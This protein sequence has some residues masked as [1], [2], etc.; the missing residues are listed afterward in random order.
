LAAP[1]I[2][3]VPGGPGF[4]SRH[5]A[6]VLGPRFGARGWAA[7]FVEEPWRL[8]R[9]LPVSWDLHIDELSKVLRTNPNSTVVAHSFAVHPAV[10]VFRDLNL[11]DCRLVLV[12]PTI[13]LQAN[14]HAIVRLAAE[15]LGQTN[16]AA[17]RQMLDHAARSASLFDVPMQQALG[18]AATD[19]TLFPRYWSDSDAFGAFAKTMSEPG[20]A[21]ELS[22]FVDVTSQLASRH[23]RIPDAPPCAIS[24]VMGDGDPIAEP[25]RTRQAVCEWASAAN[26]QVFERCGHWLH[27]EAPDRFCDFLATVTK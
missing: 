4:S 3:F 11:V 27:L 19:P 22:T 25:E 10:R 14:H 6:A 2:V 20:A 9:T 16:A 18:I 17:T 1:R 23:W 15:G 24:V 8:D 13:D 26:V 21:F 7:H 5:E 12:A